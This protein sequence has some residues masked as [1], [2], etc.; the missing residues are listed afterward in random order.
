MAEN[1]TKPRPLSDEELASI[2]DQLNRQ[3]I[4]WDSDEVSADQ[5]NNLDRYLGK[6][7]GDEEEGR[8]NAISMDVAEV[9]D[10]AM[11]DL[12]EPFISGDR[13][14]E[15]EPAKPDDE[16]WCEVASDYVNHIFFK[17]N[18]GA[19]ILYDTVKTALI[20]KIGVSK[21]V[22]REKIKEET[23]T[24]TGL[25]ALHL[26]ELQQDESVTINEITSE[27]ISQEL[28][29]DQS[30]AAAF[31]D[32][33]VYTV[34]ITRTTKDGCV[35]IC[36]V[37]PEEIKVSKRAADIES[38]DYIAH[39][40]EQTRASLIDMGFDED[41]VMELPAAARHREDSR[42]DH[43]FFDEDRRENLGR[44]RMSDTIILIEEYARVDYNG[45]GKMELLRVF[46]AGN[47]IL[48]KEE[49]SEHPFNA[50]TADRIPHRLIGL[51]LADKVKQTQ[52]IKTHLTR[53][54][55]DN[56]YLA[57]NPRLEVP[58]SAIGDNTI[59][60]LL[61]VRIGGLI[62]TKQPGQLTPVEVPDRS[63]TALEAILYMD[64]VREQQ[65]GITRN[66]TAI[67]S[68]T[69]DP[70]SAYQARKED[71]NEQA[72]KRLMCRM[73]AET[74][75]VPLFRK[76]LRLVVR[77]QDFEKMVRISGKFV[78]IDPRSWNADVAATPSVG[79][80]YTNREEELLAA[81][82]I[83]EAQMTAREMGMATPEHFWETAARM[84]RAVGWRFPDKFFVNP[85]SPEGQMALQQFAAAQGQDPKLAEVEAKAQLDQV[86]AQH[87]AQIKEM[88]QAYEVQAAQIKAENERRIAEMKAQNEYEIAQIR[89][90]AEQAIAREKMQIEERLARW[91]EELR[92]ELQREFMDKVGGAAP[93]GN[94][95][96]PTTGAVRMGGQ[97]G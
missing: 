71:R 10:W 56:V 25:S 58:E 54:L 93:S 20:Q 11:P 27:P 72:R 19:T 4:G 76:I 3:A 80:G 22:W 44:D 79:L 5:D 59:D 1:D 31:A 34:T 75:L 68:E 89:I 29:A 12:L 30:V 66:G 95:A 32:G 8:S 91:K 65:S 15:F 18:C 69:L 77:Y 36:S 41:L 49:V 74:F 82:I 26:A 43:R 62:R 52:K 61:N 35:E 53:N 88:K 7:Y 92:A 64:S 78:A 67:N 48:E 40:T 85:T 47:R 55:L 60:D 90:A 70:K 13:I 17:E 84:V 96:R 9:V 2:L 87:E 23:Q 45:D 28:L 21:S 46:R 86:K 94:G 39:E 42:A 6:P 97:I 16:E 81:R 50:W 83:G 63:K 73:I 33:M 14:V 24:L 51:A 37:P 57:N 38:V